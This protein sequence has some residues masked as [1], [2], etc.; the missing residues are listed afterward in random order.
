MVAL[1]LFCLISSWS[2]WVITL[3]DRKKHDDR[4][5]SLRPING[6]ITGE[7]ARNFFTQSKLPN[8][9]LAQI[10]SLADLT[11]D[12][13]LDKREFSIAMALIK[14]C[15]EGNQLPPSIPPAF[16]QEPISLFL[17]PQKPLATETPTSQAANGSDSKEWCIPS[18]SRPKYRL[19]FNQNDRTKRG[20]LTGVEARGIFMSSH[21]PQSTLAYIWNLADIDKD[22]N[23]TC[24]EFCIAAYLIDQALAGRTLPPTLPPSLMPTQAQ[25][26]QIDPA[27]SIGSSGR[28]ST[29]PNV[30]EGKPTPPLGGFL[31]FVFGLLHTALFDISFPEFVAERLT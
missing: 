4:F 14:K 16:L 17:E 19:Q 12:G 28:A 20:Y 1:R 21:L 11:N 9:V 6:Y 5:Q 23:L 29:E 24:D 10:W 2:S 7:Q 8:A 22:G 30:P 31:L 13:K 25:G 26:Q 27:K 18:H 3:D 15:L